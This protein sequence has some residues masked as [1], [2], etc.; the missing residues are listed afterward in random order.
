MSDVCLEMEKFGKGIGN[1]GRYRIVQVL[2]KGPKT[3]NEIVFAVKQSQPAVSQHLKTLRESKVIVS[4]R[5]GRK[6]LYSVNAEYMVALL[7]KLAEDF[8]H[9][10]RPRK[11]KAA[12]KKRR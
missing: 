4:E 9:K 1:A 11:A 2:L 8:G 5:I 12:A 6:V 10:K 3:V 7:T